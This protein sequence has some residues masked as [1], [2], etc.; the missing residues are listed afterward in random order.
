MSVHEAMPEEAVVN[1]FPVPSPVPLGWTQASSNSNY[2]I[3]T[4][5]IDMCGTSVPQTGLEIMD[6]STYHVVRTV[7]LSGNS[8][9]GQFLGTSQIDISADGKYLVYGSRGVYY[10]YPRG[11]RDIY[12]IYAL[13]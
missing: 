6:L 2:A 9:N 8:E 1:V 12:N 13:N 4:R 3:R 5:C 10:D 7:V 11:M